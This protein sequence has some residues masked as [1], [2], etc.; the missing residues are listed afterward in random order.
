M[1]VDRFADAGGVTSLVNATPVRSA[2]GAL[3]SIM[4][5][6]QDLAPLEEIERL[7]SEFLGMVSHELRTPL[8][9]IKGSAAA[10]LG[11]PRAPDPAEMLQFFHVIN[12]QADCT[13]GLIA[14]LLD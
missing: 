4:V 7:R 2:D 3:E 9:S 8:S 12:E 5:T 13:L 14:D 10:V 11:A 1:D 6:L